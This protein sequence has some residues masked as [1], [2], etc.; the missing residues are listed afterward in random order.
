MKYSVPFPLRFK[1]A[2]TTTYASSARL[3]TL[4]IFKSLMKPSAKS[5]I[6]SVLETRYWKE[7]GQVVESMGKRGLLTSPTPP[8]RPQAMDNNDDGATKS[9]NNGHATAPT[10]NNAINNK[11]DAENHDVHDDIDDHVSN[12]QSCII[13]PSHILSDGRY[14]HLPPH[15]INEQSAYFERA[16]ASHGLI[17]I[18]D[19]DRADGGRRRRR[20]T[21]GSQSKKRRRAADGDE[22]G[23]DDDKRQENTLS[24]ST[25]ASTTPFIHPLAIA[26]ARLRAHG[27]DELSKAINLGGL[28]MGGEYFGLSNIVAAAAANNDRNTAD[29]SNPNGDDDE[30]KKKKTDSTTTKTA[31]VESTNSLSSSNNNNGAIIQDEIISIDQRL[32]SSYI[33]D[34]RQLQYTTASSSLTRHARRLLSS[35]TATRIVDDRLRSLR[36]RWTMAVPEHGTSVN[37]GPVRPSETVAVDVEVYNR[38][39]NGLDGG[40]GNAAATPMGR[41]ARRVPRYATLELNDEYDIVPD[42]MS[43]KT[44]IR[45]VIDSLSQQKD[46]QG[47]DDM[48]VDDSDDDDYKKKIPPPSTL[49]NNAELVSCKTKAEPYAVATPTLVRMDSN[50]LDDPNKVPLLTLLFEIEKPSTGFVERATLSNL[51]FLS[52]LSNNNN[53]GD[54]SLDHHHTHPDEYVIESLQHSLFCASFFECIRA[55]IIPTQQSNN[56]QPHSQQQQKH[57]S[58]AWLSSKMEES[59]LPPPSLM[60]GGENDVRQ[61]LCVIHCHEGELKVQ[62]DAEYSLTVKLIEAGTAAAIGTINGPSETIQQ[63]NDSSSNSSNN[64]GM[65]QISSGSQSPR[66]LRTLCRTLLLH[67]QSLY[68]DHCMRANKIKGCSS[69]LPTTGNEVPADLLFARKKSGETKYLSTPNILQSCVTLGCKIIVE[70]KVRLLLKQISQWLKCDM[71]CSTTTDDTIDIEWL[72]LDVFCPISRFVLLFRDLCLDVEIYGHALRVTSMTEN[73]Y[74]SVGFSTDLELEYYLKLELRK[75]LLSNN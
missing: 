7:V 17:D 6:A 29:K 33:L 64:D 52:S 24:S 59:F 48:E 63:V 61:L 22:D 27:I 15:T 74:R 42:I 28:V 40:G 75:A 54:S 2:K 10:T 25:T 73:I 11:N 23:E 5:M 21:K 32:R 1:K 39:R 58:Y 9:N 62:L 4:S 30:L 71:K 49:G 26:S 19:N 41:I 70:K 65:K 35:I 69:D 44:I 8:P 16:V 14:I 56:L 38:R 72:S 13:P 12:V 53:D 43:L 18:D 45:N 46:D 3:R 36:H 47:T 66:Q 20:K 55:E 31:K 60:A 57:K 34:R 68:H 67:S 50:N 51:S 37:A